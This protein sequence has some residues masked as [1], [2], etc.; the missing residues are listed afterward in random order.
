MI[1]KAGVLYQ[2]VGKDECRMTLAPDASAGVKDEFL[3]AK[4]AKY[5]KVFGMKKTVSFFGEVGRCFERLG[6]TLLGYS[7]CFP[8][9]HF[10]TVKRA[11]YKSDKQEEKRTLRPFINIDLYCKIGCVRTD[12]S[13]WPKGKGIA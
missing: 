2:R 1:S 3:T 7:M 12:S 10:T 13:F 4:S 8:I 6:A 9:Y 11:Y 5:A